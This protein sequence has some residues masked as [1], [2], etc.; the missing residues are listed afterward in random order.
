MDKRKEGY[1]GEISVMGPSGDS[2]VFWNEK[3]WDEVEAAKGVF[4]LYKG[5]GFA[6]FRMNDK[7]DQGETMNE[8][9]PSAGSIL[10]IP[11]LAGG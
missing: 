4:D 8:F 2:K 10:F 5:K 6:A 11:A 1:T 3:K 7:G 9:D